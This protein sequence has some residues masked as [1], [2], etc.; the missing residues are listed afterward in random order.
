M[1]ATAL[2]T[3][4][5]LPAAAAYCEDHGIP[6]DWIE[7]RGK[8][9]AVVQP[10]GKARAKPL[11]K[12]KP[13]PKPKPKPRQKA[14]PKPRAKAKPKPRRERVNASPPSTCKAKTRREKKDRPAD[15]KYFREDLREIEREE[16]DAQGVYRE[17]IEKTR[18][19]CKAKRKEITKDCAAKRKRARDRYADAREDARGKR[20]EDWKSYR[21]QT[22]SKNGKRRMSAA[23]SDSLA[24]GSIPKKLHKLWRARARGYP[25]AMGYDARAEKF[26]EDVEGYYVR[27]NL[28]SN[29]LAE[30][31]DLELEDERDYSAEYAEHAA[32]ERADLE[33][34]IPF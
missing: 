7:Q 26:R 27:G 8:R 25:V 4:G 13:K 16:R 28:E 22:C 2:E 11:P 1:A 19:D 9:F 15:W 17:R 6:F 10:K 30:M 14:K 3:F 23:E 20:Q 12:N 34:E 5:E 18:K 24:E 31:I 21:A 32:R 29:D 33:D